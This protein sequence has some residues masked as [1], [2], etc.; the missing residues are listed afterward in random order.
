MVFLLFGVSAYVDVL[1]T[2]ATFAILIGL[3]MHVLYYLT[4]GHWSS[5]LLFLPIWAMLFLSPPILIYTFS[6]MLEI[7]G[8]VFFL[9]SIYYHLLFYS[10]E[11]AT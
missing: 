2:L 8:A 4:D 7:Q 10:S 3:V 5:G 9:A 6:A 1:I 11:N